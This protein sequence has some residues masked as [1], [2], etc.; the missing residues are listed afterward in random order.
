[1]CASAYTLIGVYGY[2]TF[3]SYV[4][5]DILE[6]YGGADVSVLVGIAAIAVK[7]V[8]TYPILLFCGRY[9]MYI[10]TII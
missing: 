5:S 7:S 4:S 8:T 3:G 9:C 10:I 6:N 2:L 1:M